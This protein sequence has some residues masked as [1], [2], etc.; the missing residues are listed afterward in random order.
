MSADQ[1]DHDE[2][3][4][5]LDQI[6]RSA[7]PDTWGAEKLACAN[8]QSF[9]NTVDKIAAR[10][11]VDRA[12]LRGALAHWLDHDLHAALKKY[13]IPER[14]LDEAASACTD[15]VLAD[16]DYDFLIN[17]EGNDDDN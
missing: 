16:P 11:G 13:E 10:R 17:R 5:L 8:F 14:V 1:L 6:D 9:D 2:R 12:E 3:S 15:V 4:E 7:L